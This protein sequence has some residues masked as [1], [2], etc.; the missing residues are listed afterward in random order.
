[1][2]DHSDLSQ[3]NVPR[4]V[5]RNTLVQFAGRV[6]TGLFWIAV[7]MILT[8]YLG[9]EGI[10]NYLLVLSLL[11]LLN[12]SDMGVYAIAVRE[13]SSRP[14]TEDA[15]MGNVLLIRVGLAV[16]A[17]VLVSGLALLLSYPAEV[18]MAVCLASLSYL[19]TAIGTGGL[20][21][22][23]VANLRMEFQVLSNIVQ[24]AV[25]LGLVGLVVSQGWGLI[26]LVLAYDAS[27]LANTVAVFFFSR[28]WV[29]PS[30]RLDLALC[31]RLL[32]ASLPLGLAG[33]VSM[34][35]FRVD[36]L[37]LSKM[38]GAE[39]VGLYGVAY[40]FV[41]LGLGASFFLAISVYPLLSQ[42]HA[43]G[44]SLGLQ[45]LLQ[46]SVDF[47]ALL[48]MGLCTSV[49]V[50]AEPIISFLA[51]DEF[52]PAAKTLRILSFALVLIW[53]NNMLNHA[54]MA[55]GK[56]VMVLWVDLAGL[57]VNVGLNLILIPRFGFNGAAISTIVTE[58]TLFLAVL[59]MVTKNLGY[60]PSFGAAAKLA[61]VALAAGAA[62]L[63]LA[64]DMIPLQAAVMASV[65]AAGIL[66]TRVVTID[67]LRVLLR[68]APAG[69][70]P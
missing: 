53:V 34:A 10:G 35:A 7:L 27:I 68:D 2:N 59:F 12:V 16:V 8:R 57:A 22:I 62:A 4:G 70:T 39:S 24:H 44:H 40:R 43:S 6:I 50:F 17:M 67:D 54:L 63:I 14:G 25:F 55:I 69:A 56:Q 37:M 11:A 49:I 1:M 31:R 18:T 64:P 60:L 66:I 15:L 38:K 46:R 33:I 52:L 61:P 29:M 3:I 23:F 32:W 20:G 30:L 41:D 58:F 19:F 5:A 45:R 28:R 42:Y 51:S 47:T 21:T 48:A 65:F 13:L 36:I 9:V 26:P